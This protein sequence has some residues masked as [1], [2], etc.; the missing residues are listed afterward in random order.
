MKILR[1]ILTIFFSFCFLT[2]IC[3]FSLII[4]QAAAPEDLKESIEEKSKELE[5]IENQKKEI[6]KNLDVIENQSRNLQNEI[7]QTDNNIN[8][9]NLGIR[10][11]EV[12]IEKLA[13]EINSLQYEIA[14][15]EEKIILKKEAITKILQEFQRTDT[16][17]PL[18]I[19]LRNKSL[20]ESVSDVQNLNDLS[21]G[22]KTEINALIRFKEDMANKLDQSANKKYATEIETNNLKYK[23]IILN[24]V[25]QDKKSLLS[26]TKN[27]EKVYQEIISELEKQQMKI[28]NEITDLEEALRLSFNPDLLPIKRPG[29]LAYPLSDIYVTQEYGETD[30]AK[31][32]YKTKFHNGMDFRAPIGTPILAAESGKV[33]SVGDNGKVQYGKFIVI[34]H[35]NNLATIYAHLSKQIVKE[36]EVVERGQI[37]GYSGNTGYST[38]P[39]LHFGVYWAL[40]VEM[41]G[42][43]GVGLV[44]VGVTVNPADYL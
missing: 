11:S 20:A 19:F 15:A 31:W 6:Q 42:F 9:V 1:K 28:A 10:S 36:G 41:K 21:I 23:K 38:G 29:V 24:D 17:T 30:F 26:E 40:S 44:P 12:T 8:Q 7:K 13:L 27:Q 43:S 16:E 34:K 33:F 22:L 32:A 2:I 39:H 18:I 14:D 25:K 37:I 5:E 35:D 4:S 3:H